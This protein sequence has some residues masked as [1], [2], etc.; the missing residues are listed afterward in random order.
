MTGT[1]ALPAAL[2]FDLDGTLVDSLPDM[3]R[4]MNVFLAALGRRAVS[5]QEVGR[6]VGDGA[7]ALVERAL[8]ATGG[9][10]QGALKSLTADYIACYRGH[11]AG[12]TRPYPG[13]TAVLEQ[14]HA[15]GH[16]MAVCTNK[17]YDLAI[18]VLQ[19]LGLLD[20]FQ[21]V[22][23]GDSLPVKKPDPAP[24]RAALAAMGA[25]RRR[26][27]MVGDTRND[28]LAA[29]GAGL[30]VAVVAFGYGA[31]DPRGLGG[32]V[33]IEDFADLPRLAAAYL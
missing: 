12:E 23:G 10:P 31:E 29:R 27:L 22:L 26:A 20:R 6:W 1:S 7:Q 9:L 3:L 25:E 15:Q 24:L 2:L 19:G 28:V 32:D 5:G 14:L 33:L 8:A 16:P 18:E 13:V 30:P 17:P 4:A 21:A 11:A